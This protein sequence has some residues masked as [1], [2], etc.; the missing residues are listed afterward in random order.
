[1]KIAVVGAGVTG[2][3]VAFHLAEG[4]AQVVI[5]ERAAVGSEA[6]GVQPGGVRQ[7]WSTRV[8]CVLARESTVFYRD[9][10]GRLET[11]TPPVL[12]PCGYCFLAHSIGR[13]EALAADVVLQNGLGIP[14]ELLEPDDVAELLPGIDLS[15][16][17]G[18]SF[19]AADG[20][21]DRPQAVVET[22][23]EACRRRGVAIARSRVA[24]LGGRA[25]GWTLER[26]DA[27][28]ADADAV[29]VAAG[30]D[31]PALLATVGVELPIRKE[32]RYL[33]LSEPITQRLLE[34]LVVSA[35]HHF[36][37]KHLRNGRVLASDLAAS[38]DPDIEAADW[39]AHVKASAR[40]Y[41]PLLEYVT[42]PVLVEGFYDVTP[43]HQPLVGEAAPG[44][45]VTAGFS[46]H[47]FM[48]APALGRIVA[49]A[50]LQG[51]RDPAL[52]SFALDRFARDS[53][54][55]ELQIV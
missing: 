8:N 49:D 30:Y 20:Y 32:A 40:R 21:F 18:A 19:C 36:A 6:S 45:W 17:T 44:L 42:Y 11:R 43:D 7:Q 47:G 34:P 53:F 4:G 16:V 25:A 29:V 12:E 10:A 3:S 52:E 31:A 1:V 35:E 38:G 41:L 13:R 54:A 28:P 14:S 15:D 55:P 2:L 33:L 51:R 46:G 23:A 37:A 39:R 26:D 48:I 22:F 50:L 27:D 24:G 9:L 5:H